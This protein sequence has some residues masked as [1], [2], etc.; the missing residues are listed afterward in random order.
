MLNSLARLP[1]YHETA[2]RLLHLVNIDGAGDWPSRCNHG[3]SWPAALLPYRDIHL[4]LNPLLP[5]A[6]ISLLD[7]DANQERRAKYR[8]LMR[9][10]LV[11]RIDLA[12]VERI[13]AAAEAGNREEEDNNNNDFPLDAYNGFY[14]AVAVCRHAYRWAMIPVV[15]AAQREKTLELPW[16][17]L[18]RHFG[19]RA[20]AG[21][22]TSN[23]VHNFDEKGELVYKINVGMSDLI[24]SSEDT[25]F[26][27]LYD[28]EVQAFPIYYEMIRVLTSYESG[29]KEACLRHLEE[30]HWRLRG[31]L[32]IFYDRLQDS[33][34]A[35]SVW[36]SYI[37]GFQGW[38]VGR[39][40]NNKYIKHD[41]VSGS[42]VLFFQ[43]LDAFLGLG[44][45]L[46]DE[47]MDLY[48]PR[49][50]RDLCMAL[51]EHSIRARLC[52]KEDAGI[53][54]GFDKIVDQMRVFRAAHRTRVMPYLKQPAPERMPMTAGKSLLTY[55]GG[56]SDLNEALKVLDDMLG[57]R[58]NQTV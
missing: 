53:I 11:D 57:K 52:G 22:L 14:C 34:V 13:L 27:M 28:L 5:V 36:L 58:F 16:P 26:R 17:Y 44:R 7:D 49:R 4:E 48:I 20:E 32:S 50:Q 25:F 10:L 51:R 19:C 15:K 31:S 40:I 41:G 18:Q 29:D 1:Y 30:I 12:R 3:Y 42:H 39:Y 37:Q 8:A 43:A 23:I 45:Y 54:A 2:F 55:E 47:A 24:Q 33:K 6:D 35:R 9:K 46:T 38:G 21:N 56:P